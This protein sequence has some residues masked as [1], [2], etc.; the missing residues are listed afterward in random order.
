MSWL[1]GS[2]TDF[3]D[4]DYNNIIT[5]SLAISSI[6]CARRLFKEMVGIISC[7]GLNHLIAVKSECH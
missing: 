5:G 1:G 2:L 4:E 3:D 7:Q 6:L